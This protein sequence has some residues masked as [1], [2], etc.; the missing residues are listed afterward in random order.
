M[1]TRIEGDPLDGAWRST[2]GGSPLL[3][4]DLGPLREAEALELASGLIEVSDR[5]ARDCIARAEGNPLFLE[6]LLRNAEEGADEA[7][8]ASIQSLILARMDRLA[9]ADKAALQAASAIGQRFG[10]DLLRHLIEDPGYHCTG[11]IAH[12]LVRP[13]GADYL[14]AHAL[15]REGAYSSLLKARRRELHARAAQ[16]FAEADP[17][18]HAEHL[19]R[20][21]DP[22]APQAYL[23]AAHAQAESYHYERA[24]QL[25][26]RGLAI[27]IEAAD[28]I[29][30]TCRKG[31]MLHDLGSIPESIEAYRSALDLATDDIERCR[32][33]FGLAAGMRIIDKL[34]DAL[35]ALDHAEG[36]AQ[37]HGLT[38]ELARIHHLRGN[39]YFPL[40]RMDD[41]LAAHEKSLEFARASASAEA[42]AE[43]LGGMGDA[44]YALGR[45]ASSNEY[46]RR[47]VEL[48]RQHGF[49]RI[50]V[51]NFPMVAHTR[52]FI[53]GP[54]PT[55]LD[56]LAAIAGAA[57]VGH[58]RAELNA[59][60]S[61]FIA[62]VELDRG[63][64]ASEHLERALALVRHLG[65]RRF[66]ATILGWTARVHLAEG[67]S[68]EAVERAKQAL[69]ICY[70]T[71][72]GFN[73][74]RVLGILALATGKPDERRRALEEGEKLLSEGSVGHSHLTFY[75]DAID[76]K[77]DDGDW[78]GV[79]RYAG[80]L[81]DFTRDEP[82]LW[83]TFF[84]ARG[85]A[86]AAWGRGRRDAE[87]LAELR[88][89]REE[90]ERTGFM[91]AIPALEAALG[92]AE[93]PAAVTLP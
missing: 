25:V 2:T 4:I 33:W 35:T 9:G 77:L 57:R 56:S 64:E 38:L 67:R 19:D 1:T 86:L 81:E 32:A 75:R 62:L 17:V 70:E 41:C 44:V 69:E 84:A 12:Y 54:A 46:F 29:A 66:E 10:L 30:L 92:Q 85:R 80:L 20:A 24:L 60:L 83:S 74:P 91:T 82:Y 36:L 55:I 40:G 47:C 14:F 37:S 6:Q 15:I 88:R 18:L 51:A 31:E 76:A 42:E 79:E 53:A 63:A 43:A 72:I 13:E 49:G 22:A 87:A 90:A 27:A 7:V 5:V 16:W 21:E 3:T 48:C 8:P 59:G 50:E 26:E 68:Q 93:S 65:A 39:L 89:L 34:D 45:M 58:H 11:L 52:L 71:G 23:E 78:D 28:Q 61:A 73:G